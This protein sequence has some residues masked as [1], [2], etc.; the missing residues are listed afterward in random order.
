MKV[1]VGWLYITFQ[2]FWENDHILELPLVALVLLQH[3]TQQALGLIRTEDLGRDIRD[4]EALARRKASVM[5]EG[6]L[7]NTFLL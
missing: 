3:V 7:F 5:C 2:L 1:I 6:D 4:N